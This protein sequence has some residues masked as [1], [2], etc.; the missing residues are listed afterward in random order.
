MN[1]ITHQPTKELNQGVRIDADGVY[2][3]ADLH[4][5][6]ESTAL[7][8]FAQNGSCRNHPRNRHIAQIIRDMGLGTLLCDLL[9]EEELGEDEENARYRDDAALL[10]QRLIAVTKWAGTEPMAKNLPIGYFGASAGGAA[11]L[12]AAAKMAHKV[13][14]VV[15]R[16][17]CLDLASQ[18]IPHVL[19]PTLLIAGEHDADGIAHIRKVFPHLKG[20][21][22]LHVVPGASHLFD[23]PGTMMHMADMSAEWLHRHLGKVSYCP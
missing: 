7:V 20:M 8:V 1:A 16:G 19:C 10:A 23:E 22:E 11:A 18:S 6:E 15:A 12:I 14:A 3:L 13:G 17:G 4:M 9:T 21:K 2:L 5:P